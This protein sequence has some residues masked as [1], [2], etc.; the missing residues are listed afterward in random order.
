MNKIYIKCFH[1]FH[2]GVNAVS[3][4][5]ILV[6]SLLLYL[7][8]GLFSYGY[9]NWGDTLFPFYPEESIALYLSLWNYKAGVGFSVGYNA[10]LLYYYFIFVL[11]H[12][13]IPLWIVSKIVY[14]LP[15]AMAG[16]F[17][18]ELTGSLMNDRYKHVS[19]LISALFY[20]LIIQPWQNPMFTI[21][22]AML[23]LSLTF[24]I[25]GLNSQRNSFKFALFFALTWL[26]STITPLMVPLSLGFFFI[27]FLLHAVT[28]R[29]RVRKET[30]SFLILA[31]ILTFLLSAFFILPQINN[32]FTHA[33]EP[34]L[35]FIPTQALGILEVTKS[36]TSLFYVFRLM[37][38]L[39]YFPLNVYYITPLVL[40]AG[41]MIPLYAY[42][43]LLI[44]KTK[45][46]YL[47][48]IIS[49]IFLALSTGIHYSIFSP[50]YLWLWNHV[51]YFQAFRNPYMFIYIPMLMYACLIGFTTQGILKF[52]AKR[53]LRKLL[54][55][56]AIFSIIA[57]ITIQTLPYLTY[58]SVKYVKYGTS[59]VVPREYY[60]LHNFLVANSQPGDRLLL[61][62]FGF[63]YT[64]YTW[65]TSYMLGDIIHSFSPIPVFFL[66]PEITEEWKELRSRIES[67]DPQNLPSIVKTLTLLN[68][69]Y[70][71]IH[72]D[73]PGVDTSKLQY[74]FN[75]TVYFRG[76]GSY[77]EFA[78]F[79]LKEEHSIPS[80]YI[81]PANSTIIGGLNLPTNV[82]K[83][84]SYSFR[85]V[86]PTS[87][88]GEVESNSP[89]IL[90]LNQKFDDGW[91]AH[92]D[93]EQITPTSHFKTNGYANAWYINRTGH[94]GIT[95]EYSPQKVFQMGTYISLT[96]FITCL[97]YSLL[98]YLVRPKR[99]EML[100]E[101][102]VQ[103]NFG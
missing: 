48:A 85:M 52:V 16:W 3:Y 56:T 68:I 96:T 63:R 83:E 62:P 100:D 51:P 28:N 9:W 21:S 10:S 12:L 50:V 65:Y 24:F 69:R 32:L 73:I 47:F 13:G 53:R 77:S 27:Y 34:E 11:G 49:L 60:Y 37:Y 6:V 17:T 101:S 95:I 80:V 86:T 22:E 33:L 82:N 90:I 39:M 57:I 81:S 4:V 36:F 75:N 103:N 2:V 30:L 67:N 71:F 58:G 46:T 40:T 18:Y 64:S 1:E 76:L 26:V 5:I 55:F 102:D 15:T 45:E 42:S 8:A 74:M 70:V 87:Y 38:G 98:R 84:T 92:V 66:D 14:V 25:K 35:Y 59:M 91:V 78:L 88:V 61:L 31:I 99:S 20:M 19:R 44:N 54:L 94:L 72:K 89:F 29:F 7:D 93:E 97:I 43:S 23:P 79:E 41:F